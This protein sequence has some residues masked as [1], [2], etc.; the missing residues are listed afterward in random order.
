MSGITTVSC[1]DIG[2]AWGDYP[3]QQ[4]EPVVQHCEDARNAAYEH[5]GRPPKMK[6]GKP[7][8]AALAA[9][10]AFDGKQQSEDRSTVLA[11]LAVALAFLTIACASVAACAAEAIAALRV[12]RQALQHLLLRLQMG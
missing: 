10:S 2:D 9:S 4:E 5:E 1:S 8:C 11:L 3:S 7:V 6:E 12:E